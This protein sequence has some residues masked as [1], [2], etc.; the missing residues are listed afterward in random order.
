MGRILLIE[1]DPQ[2]RSL[3]R[4]VLERAHHEVV[5]AIN[6]IEGEKIFRS[7]PTDLIVMDILMPEKEG[8]ET[9]RNLRVD[10]PHIKIIAI[11]G[12]LPHFPIDL[13]ALAKKFGA[14]RTMLKPMEIDAL[15]KIVEEEIGKD[16]FSDRSERKCTS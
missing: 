5:E 15:Q 9:I 4:E 11:S 7:T 13:L 12:G 14:C 6:G 3:I 16:H 8:L 1:D 10:F 2:V